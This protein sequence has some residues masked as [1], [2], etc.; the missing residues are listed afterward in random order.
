MLNFIKW[1]FL[2]P[3]CSIKFPSGFEFSAPP[4]LILLAVAG[5]IASVIWVSRDARKR[6]KSGLL[7]GLFAILAG[8]PVSL[9]FWLWLRPQTTKKSWSAR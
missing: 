3:D 1:F 5:F 6:G 2:K 8:W 9:I 4:F 7:G